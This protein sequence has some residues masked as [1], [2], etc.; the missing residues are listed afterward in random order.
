MI[1][2]KKEHVCCVSTTMQFFQHTLKFCIVV[3]TLQDIAIQPWQLPYL[4]TLF[5]EEIV[6]KIV[7]NSVGFQRTKKCKEIKLKN[8]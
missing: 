2:V 3:H 1:W 4:F 8:Y 6:E 7:I 5:V